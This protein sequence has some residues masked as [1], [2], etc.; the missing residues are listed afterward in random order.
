MHVVNTQPLAKGEQL[1]IDYGAE[2]W[3]SKKRPTTLPALWV[4]KRRRSERSE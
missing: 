2:Y 1:S 4:D 3:R